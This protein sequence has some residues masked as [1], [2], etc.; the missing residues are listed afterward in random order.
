MGGRRRKKSRSGPRW[1][2]YVAWAA[3]RLP[4]YRPTVADLLMFEAQYGEPR[5][6]VANVFL[7][8]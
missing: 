3:G 5:P 8:R 2:E 7:Q 4:R 6:P 1:L